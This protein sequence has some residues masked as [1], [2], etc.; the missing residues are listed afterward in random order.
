MGRSGAAILAGT[1]S[2]NA[3]GVRGLA[4]AFSRN[5][6][7]VRVRDPGVL[8]YLHKDDRHFPSR[9]LANLV[10][11]PAAACRSILCHGR[12]RGKMSNMSDP[13]PS[14]DPPSD[15]S[16]YPSTNLATPPGC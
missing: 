14:R 15:E 10:K 5:A 12:L 8:G 9:N 16:S 7:G 1:F 2:R 4:V 3:V 11:F 13:F 6:A